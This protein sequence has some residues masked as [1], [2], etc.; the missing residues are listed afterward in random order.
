M[1]LHPHREG[2]QGSRV[3]WCVQASPLGS[4]P[5][6]TKEEPQVEGSSFQTAEQEGPQEAA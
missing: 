4:P 6:P 3:A 2:A 1:P 5:S